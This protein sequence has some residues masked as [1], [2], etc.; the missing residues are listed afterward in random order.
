MMKFVSLRRVCMPM[1]AMLALL[2]CSFAIADTG[3]ARGGVETCMDCHDSASDHP[4]HNILMTP[5]GVAADSRTPMADANRQ[6]QTC[7]GPSEEHMT[8]REDGTRPPP[9]IV[10]DQATPTA[11]KD[12]TCL[13]CHQDSP[14]LHWAGSAHHFEEVACSDCHSLHVDFRDPVLSVEKQPA[15]CFECH[16]QQRAELLR[17]H[18]HPVQTANFTSE[19]GL[20]A[21]TDCHN[22]HGGPGPSNL[23]RLTV[24]ET[25]Y[26]CHAEMRGPFL[27]EHAPVREDCTT[28]HS[29]HGSVHAKMLAQRPPQL[30]Q[31]CHLA[32]RHPSGVRSG[33]GV[34]PTGADQNLLGQAC[35]NCHTNIHGSNHPSAVRF[36]R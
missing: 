36:T 22:P 28:C 14:G 11:T 19:T 12:G 29:P 34:P 24:N 30:C 27:W 5:H 8:R 20:L 33:L 16:S 23:N 18:R 31:Q 17:P 13:T 6:C 1:V 10:F 21:C 25:C 9:A 26:D 4:A 7:H 35:L 3:Y 32:Q 15:V 2:G